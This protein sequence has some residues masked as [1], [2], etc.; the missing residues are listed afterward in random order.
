M[1]EDNKNDNSR[2]PSPLLRGFFPYVWL[3]IGLFALFLILAPHVRMNGSSQLNYASS[4]LYD[5]DKNVRMIMAALLSAL[6][7]AAA[8]LLAKRRLSAEAGLVLIV[9]A[10]V[11]L[12]FGTML[13]TPFYV[14]GHDIGSFDGYGHLA[15]VYHIFETGTLP[16]SYLGQF[17]H[18]PFAHIADAVVVRLY[19][20]ISGQ[21][22]L[23]NIFEAAK[24]V[25]CFASCAL[26]LVC[27]R[28]FG[29]LDFS[30]R[31]KI[32]AMSVVAVHPTF[33][34][35]SS[36]INNDM[37]MVFFFMAAVL[38]TVRWYKDPSYK[39]ILLTA[40]FIGCA[41]STKFSGALVAVFTAAVFLVVLIRRSKAGKALPLFAQ[42]WAFAMVCFPLGLWYYVRNLL[43]FGQPIGYVA[44]LGTD[45][46]L[47]TG[48]YTVLERF[49]SFQPLRLF[50][51]IY[52][53]PWNQFNLWE[54]TAKCALF[55][56]FTF[57]DAHRV[58]AVIL[59]MASLVL[60]ILSLYAMVRLV[61]FGRRETRLGTWTLG[62]VWALLM[63]SF[64]YFNIKYPF[65]CTMD[66]RYIV[67]TVITGAGFLGLLFDRLPVG[68][69]GAALRACLIAVL[70]V[71]GVA[72]AGFYII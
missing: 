43:L 37:L 5:G 26:M 17:Y 2:P 64:V 7:I 12:R 32:I 65:G 24:L 21:T 38:Y 1:R 69:S 27:W 39:N 57:S 42:F 16:D 55:G 6:A 22:Y 36:S 68:R 58:F 56:E 53:D 61:F 34:L 14:H 71:F 72:A 54:Y 48:G 9:M 66:F 60:I 44:Q 50:R 31:A 62:A 67:P 11:I 4:T 10:G 51:E 45:S 41:M 15:Y 8:V 40:V 35:M 19:A 28:L 25:P 59:I 47:Y 52:C 3:L 18:P 46:A 13:H 30:K 33:I 63:A 29:T 49:L 23:E 70:C 20:F